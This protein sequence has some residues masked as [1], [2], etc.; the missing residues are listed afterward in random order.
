MLLVIIE[1]CCLVATVVFAGL[2]IANPTGNYEPY[3]VLA[4]VG[5][6]LSEL[7]RRRS[8]KDSLSEHDKQ[9]V[10][11]FRALFAQS[12]LIKHYK[13]HDFLLPFKRD[14]LTPLYEVVECWSDESH[15]FSN[16]ELQE[17]KLA[18][19]AAANALSEEIVRY[20]VPTGNGYVG[21][22]TRDMDPE[23]LPQHVKSEAKA[24]DEKL[25][26]FVQ[27]HEE[28]IQLTNKLS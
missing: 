19:F 20:T 23:N 17:K 21:V 26:A 5:L 3:T 10:Q 14:Y 12:G 27:A 25:P 8:S 1:I 6:T 13:E 24:I 15:S 2:W 9:L 28:L 22:I 18:F 16:A 11:A 4:G 7:V